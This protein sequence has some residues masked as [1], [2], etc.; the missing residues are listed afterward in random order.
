M[1]LADENL[2]IFILLPDNTERTAEN[3]EEIARHDD[4]FG[5]ERQAWQKYQENLKRSQAQE[6]CQSM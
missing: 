5:V 3:P 6:M 4:L 2:E 1:R